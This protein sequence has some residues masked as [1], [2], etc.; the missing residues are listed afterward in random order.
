MRQ[1]ITLEYKSK[2]QPSIIITVKDKDFT[3]PKKKV[4]MLP[5][6]SLLQI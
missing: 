4:L 1:L 6:T 2:R 3:N 5:T